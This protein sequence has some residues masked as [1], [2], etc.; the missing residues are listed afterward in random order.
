VVS[1]DTPGICPS[2]HLPNRSS[3][4]ATVSRRWPWR[5]TT[6]TWPKQT[7]P[8]PPTTSVSCTAPEV[9]KSGG[10]GRCFR[11]GWSGQNTHQTKTQ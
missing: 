3:P 4:G 7:L 9:T 1:A 5:T 6:S 10:C 8:H 11:S 2:V